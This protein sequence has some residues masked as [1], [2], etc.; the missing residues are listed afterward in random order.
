MKLENERQREV[1]LAQRNRL[2][3]AVDDLVTSHVDV[4]SRVVQLALASMIGQ[5]RDL[6]AQLKEYDQ[7]H[8]DSLA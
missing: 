6:D 3:N 4:D 1:T 2:M 7:S 8:C 5:V